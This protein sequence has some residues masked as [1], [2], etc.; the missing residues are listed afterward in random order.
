MSD[1]MH[2]APEAAL[3]YRDFD[4]QYLAGDWHTGRS[5]QEHTDTNPF[6][7]DVLATIPLA[8]QDDVDMAYKG[9]AQAQRDWAID[10]FTRAQWITL[11]YE[12]RQ[13]PF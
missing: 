2:P 7:G 6:D 4:K 13:Y 8:S 10:E 12:P 3:P 11:Q 1:A 9:A 5:G